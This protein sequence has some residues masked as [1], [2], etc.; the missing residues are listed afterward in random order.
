MG[1]PLKMVQPALNKVAPGQQTVSEFSS[2]YLATSFLQSHSL[3]TNGWQNSVSVSYSYYSCVLFFTRLITNSL[4]EAPT[5]GFEHKNH[6]TN[7]FQKK[8]LKQ[9]KPL[10]LHQKICLNWLLKNHQ[11]EIRRFHHEYPNNLMLLSGLEPFGTFTWLRN[12][13]VSYRGYL[14]VMC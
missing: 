2:Y 1:L 5:I 10:C 12:L 11:V 8:F 3:I 4:R 13:G 7:V 14:T 9:R 6:T